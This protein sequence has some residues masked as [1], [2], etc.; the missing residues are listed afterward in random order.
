M[1]SKNFETIRSSLH[2]IYRLAESFKANSDSHIRHLEIN[3]LYDMVIDHVNN[4]EGED[5]EVSALDD[6][7]TDIDNTMKEMGV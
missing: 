2:G 5:S 6:L 3:A 1:R 7:V 4:F